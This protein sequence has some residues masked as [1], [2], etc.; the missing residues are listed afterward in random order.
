[1]LYVSRR[2]GLL[3]VWWVKM[4]RSFASF[5]SPTSFNPWLKIRSHLKALLNHGN[6]S[7]FCFKVLGRIG[8]ILI[9][10]VCEL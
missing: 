6:A 10:C 3:S 8:F 5:R 1:M 2:S 9:G 7:S 4:L